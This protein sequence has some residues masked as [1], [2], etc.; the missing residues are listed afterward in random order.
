MGVRRLE[1]SARRALDGLNQQLAAGLLA[2]AAAPALAAV[3]DQHAAAVRDILTVG[4]ESGAAVAGIVLLAGY[5]QGVQ[6]HLRDRGIQLAVPTDTAGWLTASWFHVRLL[7]VCA[8]AKNLHHSRP[9]TD[10]A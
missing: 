2:T 5:A 8:L 3:V 4:V 9:V 7:A 1:R 6:D 10:L